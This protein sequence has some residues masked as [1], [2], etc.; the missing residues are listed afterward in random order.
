MTKVPPELTIS[1]KDVCTRF[2][3]IHTP[4]ILDGE[5][6]ELTPI[7][8]EIVNGAVSIGPASGSDPSG[9]A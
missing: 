2:A 7:A 6:R 3:A 4:Y 9:G 5:T 1:G 8:I